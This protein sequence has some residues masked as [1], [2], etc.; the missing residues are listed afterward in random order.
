MSDKSKVTLYLIEL[1]KKGLFGKY[2]KR[3]GVTSSYMRHRLQ[4]GKYKPSESVLR[5]MAKHSNRKLVRDDIECH[6]E[7]AENL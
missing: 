6:F 5:A 2:C 3:V 4:G 1:T 7:K